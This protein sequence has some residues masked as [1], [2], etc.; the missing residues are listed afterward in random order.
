M[1]YFCWIVPSFCLPWTAQGQ[2]LRTQQWT[3]ARVAVAVIYIFLKQRQTFFSTLLQCKQEISCHYILLFSSSFTLCISQLSMPIQSRS[4]PI[5]KMGCLHAC[6]MA[7]DGLGGWRPLACGSAW[8]RGGALLAPVHYWAS[9]GH[10]S[11]I[12]SA[13]Q[14]Y[15]SYWSTHFMKVESDCL[16]LFKRVLCKSE[17]LINQ[18]DEENWALL[19]S[20][21]LQIQ[22]FWCSAAKPDGFIFPLYCFGGTFSSAGSQRTAHSKVPAQTSAH[23]RTGCSL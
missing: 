10:S 14:Q 5:I 7:W 16:P 19:S 8:R 23:L 6:H 2:N 3:Y 4:S 12:I 18:E 22:K 21:G 15:T 20:K 9:M 11:V 13:G 17:K 1:H